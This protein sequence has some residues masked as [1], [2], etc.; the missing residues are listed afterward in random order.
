MLQA[1]YQERY[2]YSQE[3]YE[4]LVSM[5]RNGPR[6]TPWNH[7][8]KNGKRVTYHTRTNRTRAMRATRTMEFYERELCI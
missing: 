5:L 7:M 3:N 6:W 4:A 1:L 2:S 8:T